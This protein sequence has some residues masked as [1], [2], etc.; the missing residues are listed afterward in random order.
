MRADLGDGFVLRHAT[1]DDHHALKRVCLRTGNAG[2]DA[3]AREDDPDLLGLIY[4]V[5]YQLYAP[6]FAFVL[7]HTEGV[8]GYVLGALDTAAFN[9]TLLA[10][11][12]PQLQRRVTDPG[13]DPATWRGSDWARAM[14]HRPDLSLP[15]PLAPYPSHGHIDLLE[16]A[17]GR[18]LGRKMMA[19]LEQALRVAGSSGLHLAVDPRN[20]NARRFYT[21]VGYEQLDAWPDT[22]AMVKRLTSTG[23]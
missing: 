20:R 5:P 8:C 14:I 12:Y 22:V 3:T 2:K 15:A 18:G 6:D 17:R 11:W 1:A 23:S 9:A 16:S 19:H 13:P 10:E 7:E 4:A 21:A